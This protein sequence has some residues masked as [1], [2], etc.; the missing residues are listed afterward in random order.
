MLESSYH[1]SGICIKLWY[2]E[3]F[4][5]YVSVVTSF[6]MPTFTRKNDLIC[7][8]YLSETQQKIYEAFVQ[9]EE[10]R[11]VCRMLCLSVSHKYIYIWWC[12]LFDFISEISWKIFIFKLSMFQSWYNMMEHWH[13]I[14]SSCIIFPGQLK[15]S[16]RKPMENVWKQH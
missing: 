1:C 13:I 8:V 15:F 14:K 12:F 9:T 7:W 11:D 5:G 2:N 10:V 16:P 6:R 4:S 3:F